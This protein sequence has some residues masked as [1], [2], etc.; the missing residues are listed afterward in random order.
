MPPEDLLPEDLLPEHLQ[1]PVEPPPQPRRDPFWGY[2]DLAM[3]MG[4]LFASIV[5]ILVA[6]GLFIAT[7]PDLKTDR[8]FC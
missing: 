1:T 4:L 6:A 7:R 3:V 8:Y 5:L 2:S